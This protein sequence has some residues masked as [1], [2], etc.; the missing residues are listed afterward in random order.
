MALGYAGHILTDVCWREDLLL[1]FRGQ[2]EDRLQ[3]NEMPVAE[4]RALYYNECDKLDLDL[5]DRQSWRLEVWT[6]LRTACAVDLD[7]LLSADEIAGWRDRVLAW[8]EDNRDKALYT[9]Q[10]LTLERVLAFVDDA[11]A[12]VH[13]QLINDPS[14]RRNRCAPPVSR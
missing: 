5:Y 8:F 10:Y 11:A 3:R 7:G 12:R 1:P 9:P 13:Y 2:F 6:L 4:L 14:S